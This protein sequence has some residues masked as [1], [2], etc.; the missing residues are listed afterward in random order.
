MKTIFYLLGALLIIVAVV[1]FLV[2]ADSLPS[3]MPGHEDGLA[4]VRV[5][6]GMASGAAGVI[7]FAI[8]WFMG[9]TRG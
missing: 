1:Y 3:L 5:K 9:R 7:L 2:P 4:R 6:H 8:G